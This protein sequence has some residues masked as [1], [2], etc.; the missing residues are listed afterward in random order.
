MAEF[1]ASR[2]E[3]RKQRETYEQTRLQWL[4]SG[5]RLRMLSARR[6]AL[7]RQRGPN[8]PDYLQQRQALD[9]K[10]AAERKGQEV[11]ERAL[12]SQQALLERAEKV[13]SAFQ[14]PRR[15]L[16]AHFPS[17]TPFLLFP[18]R[19]ETRFKRVDG[20]P[21]LWVRV[22]PDECLV[23]SFDP[24]LS[25]TE[26]SNAARFWAE[27]YSVGSTDPDDPD[28]AV[29]E[30]QKAAWRL[31]VSTC[32]DGRAA[33]IV[34]QLLPDAGTSVFPARGPKTV[35]LA[36]VADGWDP[37]RQDAI[38]GLFRDLWLA[39]GRTERINEVKDSFDAAHQAEGLSADAVIAA[40]EP[41][42]FGE[43]LPAGLS[44]EEADLQFAI[45]VFPD[46]EQKAGKDKGW[47]LPTRVTLLPERLA[48]IRVKDGA[49]MEPVF[50]R[51]IPYP[52]PT[53][54]DPAA[55][56]EQFVTDEHGDLVF[57][58]QIRWVADFDRAV[59]IG[60]G[61]RLPL[62]PDE[63]N[64]FERLL[65]LGVRL[66]AGADEGRKL[67]EELFDHHFFS[68][69]G[70]SLIPQGTPTNN[71]EAEDAGFTESS[72]P[73]ESFDQYF[74]QKPGFTVSARPEDRSDGQWLAEWL[75]LDF[76]VLQKV[77][78]SGGGDQREVR[79]MNTALW[80]ATL[81]YVMESLME[82]GFSAEGI[83]HTRDFFSAF[84]SG[85]GPLPAI[86]IGNQP[87]GI[88]PTAPF[89]RLGWMR[90]DP[91]LT[92]LPDPFLW[93]LYQLLLRMDA[94]LDGQLLNGVAH[95]GRAG[96]DPYQ[97][98]LDIVGLHPGSVEYH[99]RYMETLIEMT[100]TMSL[101][102]PAYTYHADAVAATVGLLHDT[103]GYPSD[104]LPQLAALY[105]L[106]WQRLITVLI[107][108]R[109]LSETDP[110]RAY[111][112]DG[113][114]YIAALA[115][116]ARSSLD[117][118]RTGAGFS[119]R[120]AA[121]LY[122]LLKYALEQEYHSSSLGA[123]LAAEAFS[124]KDIS[125]MRVEQPFIHQTWKGAVTESRYKL[126]Y[127]TV[128]QISPDK[129][130][131][132][133]IRD[134]LLLETVPAY[135]RYLSRQLDALDA[136]KDLPTARLERA[137][138]EHIDCCSYRLD[139]W[140]T[141]LLTCGLAQLRQNGDKTEGRR[142]GLYLGAFGWLEE[143]R[144]EKNKVLTAVTLP[145]ELAADFNP[146]GDKVFW[147]DAA[148]EG[149]IHAP[150][151]N[152]GV[153][154]AVLRNGYV[155]HGKADDNEVMAVNLTSERIREGLSLIE[156]IQGGQPLAAL[157][158]YRFERELHDRSDLTGQGIDRFIYALRKQFPLNAEQIRDT[159]TS[160]TTDPSVDPDS[161]P[162]TAIE[163][164][165]VVHGVHLSQHVAAQTGAVRSY[166]FGLA[167]PAAGAAVAAA[168]TAAAE[169]LLALSDAIADLGIAESVHQTLMGNTDRAAGVLEAYSKG[170]YPQA[171][172]VIRTP[173]G[174]TTLTHRVGIPL[175]FVEQDGAAGPRGG[176]EPSVN[177]WLAAMLPLPDKI[178]CHCSYT[179]LADGALHETDVSMA[180]LGLAPID[181]VYILSPRGDAGMSEMDDRLLHY[182]Q[183]PAGPGLQVDGA[184]TLQYTHLYD[185]PDLYA[186]FQVTPL[187]RSLAALTLSSA[188]LRPGDI[189]IPGEASAQ[190]QPAPWLPEQRVQDLVSG[191]KALLDAAEGS[192]G[193]LAYLAGLP[194]MDSASEAQAADMRAQVDSTLKN[195]AALLLA[196]GHYGIPQ[197]G[198][199]EL[200]E[201]RR[202]WFSTLKGR[203]RE[204]V[205]R[206]QSRADEYAL[207]EAQPVTPERLQAMERLISATPTAPA[208]I[209]AA[210]VAAKKA[211]FDTAFAALQAAADSRQ[212]GLKELL[213]E[214][215][216]LDTASFDLVP[217]EVSDV[218]KQVFRYLYELQ[219]RAATL[220][221][222]LRGKRLPEAEAI[223]AELPALSAEDRALR[224]EAA[225]RVLLG[226]SFRMI[227]RYTLAP[228]QQ[229]ELAN[230][231]NAADTLLQYLH[232][233]GRDNPEEDWLHGIARVHEKMGHLEN[234]LLL[235][236]AFALNEDQLRLHPVQLP[237][238]TEKY[239]WMALPFPVDEVDP[240]DG[241]IL[242]YT[243]AVAAGSPAPTELC[244]LLAD[245]WVELLP[246]TEQV[247][248]V[249]FHYDRPSTEAPQAML[250][251]TPAQFEGHWN[252]DDL[253][254]ALIYT[255]DAARS[256]AIEPD[257][258]AATPLASL[259]PA[260]VSAESLFPYSIVLDNDFHYLSLDQVRTFNAIN[261]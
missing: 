167:L 175:T 47:T 40:Y 84:V 239:H 24:L 63:V 11:L 156:G 200:Y 230:A 191:L 253:V 260:V 152:Q 35:I 27:Y 153:T 76:G 108:D 247:T 259:L 208:D 34:R 25:R 60:M 80:P 36:L 89:R 207:L 149:Y 228:A 59:E 100:N 88:L 170:N 10:I 85:R 2:D 246:A 193:V 124:P 29:L 116:Q 121:E 248:G 229:E 7:E 13:F 231:W 98:L 125:R 258:I 14:D 154:A 210:A 225:A 251:V 20:S 75:G 102:K 255:M 222:D 186:L 43:P 134:S 33:W 64:G 95:V 18:L 119:E 137:L 61:F 195:L 51:P 45:V 181:L 169:H 118:L 201:R 196:L 233:G 9:E 199:G 91:R 261:P 238:R 158:G 94:Y 173:R 77:L 82:D 66:A 17:Q 62:A 254:D 136:L 39:D 146:D 32:S 55:M 190:T 58:E 6:S 168:I 99:R 183:G 205:A 115:D 252:W 179:A 117:A 155:S 50:G 90:P 38:T 227:P 161:I 72:R 198:A 28:P 164:R 165:N 83:A 123:A 104:A 135:S 101:I 52:L 241:Q 224:T 109:P 138:A 214:V 57:G 142:L 114:N 74:L 12:N 250:L 67:L 26:V 148:N 242:L 240:E 93:N 44:R 68:K 103:L 213:Q 111:T 131:A 140:K 236:E 257:S 203:L 70:F 249:A 163:A 133:F 219:G 21:Q 78:H 215:E 122:R 22:F 30:G 216:A 150:S 71:T 139:S 226:D 147:E 189:A 41:V 145:P 182:L 256:R 220:L 177:R 53:S 144:P 37:A 235:R 126:L 211:L 184:L 79:H 244:G 185:D 245:E 143:V 65:V 113:R 243:A 110:V 69:K 42:N 54:P 107:D 209:T 46:L 128:P 97:T 202:Q 194:D 105:G 171:P 5:Q 223:L 81:G 127:D 159:A 73:D 8:H 19:L 49:P 160:A 112:A 221:A 16:A 86:R 178:C 188:T 120:P 180:Q 31:L 141:G 174:G 56:E 212:A 187:I 197:T 232:D 106:P 87:Y 132:A 3:L 204:L 96:A 1:Q 237:Y 130:V 234:C 23:D 166:P 162:I 4:S 172:E 157:L 217:L 176:A 151:L 92:R 129:P 15:E 218:Q 206:W 192:G 48:L